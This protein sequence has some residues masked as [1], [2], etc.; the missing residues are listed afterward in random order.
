MNNFD[1]P[2]NIK[3]IGT[4]GNGL[5]IY[6]EDYV[7]S[8]LQQY[9]EA[10]GYEERLATLVGRYITIDSQPVIFVSGAIIGKYCEEESGIKVFSEKGFDY[11]N[12]QIA[13]HFKG[14]EVV[15]FMQ[16]Q[17]GYGTFLNPNYENYYLKNFKKLY[18][19]MFVIDPVEKLNSFFIPQEGRLQETKGYFV[20]YE[21]NHNMHE[22]MM[23]NKIP[24]IITDKKIVPESKVSNKPPAFKDFDDEDMED[25]DSMSYVASSR[26]EPFNPFD[27]YDKLEAQREKEDEF[28]QYSK[29]QK[30]SKEKP[31]KEKKDKTSKEKNSEKVESKASNTR[32]VNMLVSMCSVML[33]ICFVLAAGL[34]RSDDRISGLE[35]SLQTLNTSHANVVVALQATQDAF[36]AQITNANLASLIEEDGNTLLLGTTEEPEEVQAEPVASLPDSEPEVIEVTQ[37]ETT[38]GI[39]TNTADIIPVSQ[40]GTIPAT[41]TVQPGDNLLHISQMFYGTTDMVASIMEANN[42]EDANTL[43][44]GKVLILPR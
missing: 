3:Q 24:K 11:V 33:L 9:A 27:A 20:Y 31:Q 21:K 12:K 6:V 44:H 28:T 34:I 1:F 10:G 37:N 36:A 16:S 19:V 8:Y 17:P 23:E 30:N 29:K 4:I 5:R 41:Y 18:H 42:M 35:D 26:N 7:C 25:Y 13:L 14:L 2:T 40:E 38:T 39:I 43:F 32:I 22:Y 15:G